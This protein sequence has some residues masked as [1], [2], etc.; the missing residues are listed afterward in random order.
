MRLI[1][2]MR[3][4]TSTKNKGIPEQSQGME[5]R[6]VLGIIHDGGDHVYL[7]ILLCDALPSSPLLSSSPRHS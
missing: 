4:N 1:R 3:G 5:Q 7:C 2:K 6:N